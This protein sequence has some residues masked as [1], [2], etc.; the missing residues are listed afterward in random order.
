MSLTTQKRLGG[1]FFDSENHIYINKLNHI[2]KNY[3]TA[4]KDVR[5]RYPLPNHFLSFWSRSEKLKNFWMMTS[6]PKSKNNVSPSMM[7]PTA[8]STTSISCSPSRS[9][10][11]RWSKKFLSFTSTRKSLSL[12]RTLSTRRPSRTPCSPNWTAMCSETTSGGKK[13]TGL[14]KTELL[15]LKR[16]YTPWRGNWRALSPKMSKF[17]S[18]KERSP[19]KSFMK[20]AP[21]FTRCKPSWWHQTRD[22]AKR[23]QH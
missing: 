17:W 6:C 7:W 21:I 10:C 16:D 13:E 15:C 8:S 22:S 3:D 11:R 19:T 23:R 9:T 18:S 4:F 12:Q 1:D 20:S 5:N 14:S 2:C